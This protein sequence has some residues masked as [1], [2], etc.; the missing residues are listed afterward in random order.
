M[1]PAEFKAFFTEAHPVAVDFAEADYRANEAEVSKIAR[2]CGYRLAGIRLGRAV[3]T[4][5]PRAPDA[6]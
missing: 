3:F 6:P 5:K 1:T 2:D 4:T